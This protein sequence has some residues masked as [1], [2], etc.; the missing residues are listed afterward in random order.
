MSYMITVEIMLSKWCLVIKQGS[1][2]VGTETT[3]FSLH[4]K[5]K[6]KNKT[7]LNLGKRKLEKQMVVY[8][9]DEQ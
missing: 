2:F 9:T 3:L 6:R 8:C 4:K 5:D 1:R 7:C